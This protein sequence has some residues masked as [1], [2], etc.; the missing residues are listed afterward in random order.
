[1]EYEQARAYLAS[2]LPADV[3]FKL[4][5]A[6]A[7][8]DTHAQTTADLRGFLERQH[9]QSINVEAASFRLG[10]APRPA[11]SASTQRPFVSIE[12]V[13][14]PAPYFRPAASHFAASAPFCVQPPLTGH[15]ATPPDCSRQAGGYRPTESLNTKQ[16]PY[17]GCGG[18]V[19]QPSQCCDYDGAVRPRRQCKAKDPSTTQLPMRAV[20]ADLSGTDAGRVFIVRKIHRLG[21]RAAADLRK[22][23]ES[24]GAVD[25]VLAPHA[26]VLSSCRRFVRRWR[27]SNLA[28][29]VMADAAAVSE[30]MAAGRQQL[31][32][33]HGV[34]VERYEQQAVEL[35]GKGG[36]GATSIVSMG[37]VA[38]M[39]D[40]ASTGDGASTCDSASASNSASTGDSASMCDANESAELS[41][42]FDCG[43]D[44][45]A[46]CA[47]AAEFEYW[48]TDDEWD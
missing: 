43:D 35:E 9:S 38:S 15:V 22:H 27:P 34:V 13:C 41:A 40:G 37:G 39:F 33:G 7:H 16:F 45:E 44:G 24:Y 47:V 12:P 6:F 11:P 19:V 29:V 25:D 17:A 21:L 26:Q 18:A 1:M 28:F 10:G 31:V 48:A 32:M 2:M 46:D 5:H 3:L 20:L 14:S 4:A 42:E 36:S 23:F 30:V 8:E